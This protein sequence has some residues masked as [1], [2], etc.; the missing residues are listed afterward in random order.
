ML[1]LVSNTIHQQTHL[2]SMLFAKS[3][4]AFFSTGESGVG[5]FGELRSQLTKGKERSLI[6]LVDI[7]IKVI[8]PS[9]YIPCNNN[10]LPFQCCTVSMYSIEMSRFNALYVFILGLNKFIYFVAFFLTFL[11]KNP[12]LFCLPS[13]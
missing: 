12:G 13:H 9:L 7:T 8:Q 5:M 3:T 10:P 6:L 11:T 2:S 4:F 1:L